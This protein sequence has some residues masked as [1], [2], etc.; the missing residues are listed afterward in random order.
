MSDR[1]CSIDGCD[2]SVVA[3]GWCRKH[4]SRWHRHGAPDITLNPIGSPMMERL[5]AKVD[6]R[7]PEECWLWTGSCTDGYGHVGNGAGK[8][9]LVHRAVYEALVGPIPEGLVLDHVRARGCLD[10][11]CV[12]P[13]HLEPV[14]FAENVSRGKSGQFQAA[15]THCPQGHPYDEANTYVAPSGSRCCRICKRAALL[16]SKARRRSP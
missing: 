16:R 10:R 4:Y 9:V 3:R 12:N 1:T 2:G 11:R 8:L 13:A 5:W 6:R 7:G 15:K 14:T